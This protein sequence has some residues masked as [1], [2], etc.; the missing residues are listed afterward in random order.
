MF[1]KLVEIRPKLPN[2]ESESDFK[3]CLDGLS[4]FGEVWQARDLPSSRIGNA[5]VH[6]TK[7]NVEEPKRSRLLW[8]KGQYQ[9]PPHIIGVWVAHIY[10]ATLENTFIDVFNQD[11]ASRSNV[12]GTVLWVRAGSNRF[13]DRC[14]RCK[15]LKDDEHGIYWLDNRDC[16][17]IDLKNAFILAVT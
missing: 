11:M 10:H 17:Y 9:L 15:D 4:L 2:S 12:L 16:E 1:H 14:T 7:Q 5:P 8:Q 3:L 13:D 6:I